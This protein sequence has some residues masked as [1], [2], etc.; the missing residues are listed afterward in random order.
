[1]KQYIVV[2]DQRIAKGAGGKGPRQKKIKTRQ[3]VSKSF[4]RHFSTI[5]AQGKKLR[6]NKSHLLARGL[7]GG[8][9]AFLWFISGFFQV[10]DIHVLPLVFGT[11]PQAAV[12]SLILGVQQLKD[13]GSVGDQSLQVHT[14][15]T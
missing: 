13:S 3:K 15:L 2:F 9:V 7:D 8:R 12:A 11:G 10:E 6:K 4:S 14:A 1:M 5:F